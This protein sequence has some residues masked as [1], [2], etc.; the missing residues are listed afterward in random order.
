MSSTCGGLGSGC[1]V[2][3]AILRIGEEGGDKGGEGGREGGG[4]GDEGNVSRTVSGRG[5]P[6]TWGVA[7][8]I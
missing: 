6:I 1:S 7:I 5:P 2:G 8:G 3:G 4:G